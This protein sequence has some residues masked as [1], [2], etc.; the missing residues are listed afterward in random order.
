M[1]NWAEIR[2]RVLAD[3]LSR[4]AACRE[5]NIHW[6][7]LKRILDTPEPP[8]SRRAKTK[9]PSILEPLLPV[10]H[11]ILEDDR[12]AP[13]KQRHTAQRVF[14]RLR[15]EHGYQGGLPTVK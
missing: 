11:Q 12:K 8:G 15:D 9:R 7:T 4:R 10:V 3:G 5:F 1:E 14:E 13:K 2:R 6:K